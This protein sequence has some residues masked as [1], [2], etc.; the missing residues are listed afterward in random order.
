MKFRENAST[1]SNMDIRSKDNSS[2]VFLQNTK[3]RLKWKETVEK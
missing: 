1:G 2:L 3:N